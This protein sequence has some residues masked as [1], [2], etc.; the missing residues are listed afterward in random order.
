MAEQ[1]RKWKSQ[2]RTLIEKFERFRAQKG[3]IVKIEEKKKKG[4]IDKFRRLDT[5]KEEVRDLLDSEKKRRKE[6][7]NL[8]VLDQQENLLMQHKHQEMV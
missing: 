3:E 2:R 8:K 1:K 5:A 6:L 7:S 4:L